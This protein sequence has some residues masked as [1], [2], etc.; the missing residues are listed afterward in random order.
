[1]RLFY[2]DQYREVHIKVFNTGKLEIPGIKDSEFFELII[3][4]AK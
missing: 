3:K 4:R 2:D 1:M